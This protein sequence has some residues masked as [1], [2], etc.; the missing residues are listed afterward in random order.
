MEH[1]EYI[2]EVSSEISST[3]QD[4]KCQPIIFAGTGLSKR[5]FSAP[6]WE[7]LLKKL[8]S[9]CPKG[10]DSIE[11][12]LQQGDSLPKVGSKIADDYYKWGYDDDSAFPNNLRSREYSSNIFIKNKISEILNSKTPSGPDKIND[13]RL[14][15][16][17]S[18]LKSINPHTIVTTN[19]DTFLE[20]IFPEYQ[21]VIGESVLQSPH[22]SVGEVMKIHGC[23]TEPESMVLTE[24]DYNEFI[25]KKKYLSAK[26]LTYFSEHPVLIV[27]YSIG[28]RNVQRI[29]SDI[30]EAL[31][32]P[33]N[34][35]ENIYFLKWNKK[36]PS[37]NNKP[38]T[39][40]LTLNNN[41]KI[42]L[43]Y[44]ESK[45]FDWV[46]EAFASGGS[47]EGVNLK[48]LRSVVA[49]T[50]DVVKKKAPKEEVSINYDSLSRAANSE[51]SIGT[52]Y[53]VTS[54]DDAPDFNFIYRYRLSDVAEE[55][56]YDT[57]YYANEHIVEIEEKCGINIKETDN[58]YHMNATPQ[59]DNP[60]HMY[61]NAAIELLRKVKNG[62]EY[63]V[64]I[65]EG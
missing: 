48:L 38:R 6:G 61:S 30:D 56:G 49:N 12:Y 24:E 46:F 27:G 59:A 20:N 37:Q 28:D 10:R 58:K 21:R 2:E 9:I 64:E 65:D 35:I 60:Q 23:V 52:M 4:M 13:E 3:V 44:I 22:E 36:A 26:L 5:Y 17:I 62:E 19:Y 51:E 40:E 63:T 8:N 43:K 14:K 18:K 55:L 50:Y 1:S 7:C 42:R 54:L 32:Q 45:D 11:Y 53:G 47:I 31:S 16:E 25:K 39:K 41:N 15:S 34:T 57:W 33:D 29:L